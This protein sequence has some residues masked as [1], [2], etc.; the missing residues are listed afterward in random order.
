MSHQLKYRALRDNHDIAESELEQRIGEGLSLDEIA[1]LHGVNLTELNS[2][3]H[4]E[5][6]RLNRI[7]R[8]YSSY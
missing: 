3:V 4:E 6:C 5:I 8:F 2:F 7:N 1:E